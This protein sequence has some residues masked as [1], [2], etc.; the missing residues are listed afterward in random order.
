MLIAKNLDFYVLAMYTPVPGSQNHDLV[1]VV[2]AILRS[3]ANKHCHTGVCREPSILE[4]ICS[5]SKKNLM[6]GIIVTFSW[7]TSGKYVRTE[8]ILCDIF[9][10]RV[11]YVYYQPSNSFMSW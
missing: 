1:L 3:N 6:F 5:H 11:P 4:N 8:R 2:I 9:T 10:I 7:E